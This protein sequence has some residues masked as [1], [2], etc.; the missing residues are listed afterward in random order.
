MDHGH[1]G[2]GSGSRLIAS[3]L[4]LDVN[5]SGELQAHQ[6]LDRLVG[7]LQNVDQTLMGA[8]LKLL[9]AVLVLMNSAQQ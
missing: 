7:R 4:D 1:S 5:A 3:E 9:T 8:G 6:S 2:R